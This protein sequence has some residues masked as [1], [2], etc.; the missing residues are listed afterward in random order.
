MIN[1][2][3]SGTVTKP[4]RCYGEHDR[5]LEDT[6]ATTIAKYQENFANFRFQN[7]LN[8]VWQLINRSNKY[9]DETTPW[10]VARMRPAATE[11]NAILYH[12]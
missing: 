11:L 8:E 5:E 1:K 6:I 4:D 12:L 2:Y 9:I 7:G 10:L 3:Q